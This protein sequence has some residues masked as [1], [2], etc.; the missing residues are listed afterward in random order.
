M[1]K[2][3]GE[4]QLWVLLRHIPVMGQ[5]D[6]AMVILLRIFLRTGRVIARREEWIVREGG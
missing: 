6:E 3:S 5:D 4:H 1:R 2:R